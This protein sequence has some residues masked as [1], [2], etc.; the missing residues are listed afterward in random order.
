MPGIPEFRG[1][2]EEE[3][4]PDF[5]ASLSYTV[6]MLLTYDSFLGYLSKIN[7]IKPHTKMGILDGCINVPGGS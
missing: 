2:G 6:N 1:P 7:V 5:E 3:N 4:C